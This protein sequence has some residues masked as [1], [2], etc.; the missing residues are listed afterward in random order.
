MDTQS[1][2]PPVE[3]RE[4]GPPFPTFDWRLAYP[5]IKKRP[6]LAAALD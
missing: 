4:T 1:S 5:W 2:P 6:G 3:P